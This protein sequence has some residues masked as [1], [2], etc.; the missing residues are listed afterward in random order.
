MGNPGYNNSRTNSGN[1]GA[2]GP[3]LTTTM[4]INMHD[5]IMLFIL[6]PLA[7]SYLAFLEGCEWVRANR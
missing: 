1:R 5:P 7:I 6:Y 3:Y 4:E 2:G